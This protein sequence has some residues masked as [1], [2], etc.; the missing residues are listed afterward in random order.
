MPSKETDPSRRNF[1][2]RSRRGSAIHICETLCSAGARSVGRKPYGQGSSPIVPRRDAPLRRPFTASGFQTKSTIWSRTS[3]GV[4]VLV[5]VPQDFFLTPCARP[6][7]RPELH[8]WSGSSSPAARCV[9]VRAGYCGGCWSGRQRIRFQRTPS[10][11]GRIPSALQRQLVAELWDRLLVHQMP[12][13]N[14]DLLLGCIALSC[15]FHAFPPL[16]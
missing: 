16:A 1:S 2:D 15:F 7:T 13:Q 12:S 6:S 11:C 8:P 3:G 5:R 4:Q 14:G 10:A 9:P